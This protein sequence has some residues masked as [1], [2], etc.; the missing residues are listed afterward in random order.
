MKTAR[1]L[2]SKHATAFSRETVTHFF[3]LLKGEVIDPG[4]PTRNIFNFDEKGI[5]LG[6]GHKNIRTKYIFSATD[7]NRYVKKSDNLV[8]VTILECVSAVG[9]SCPPIFVLP[10]GSVREW[11]HAAGVG[12]VVASENGW[13]DDTICVDWFER[14]FVP[15]AKTES[16]PTYPIIFISDRHGSHET[17]TICLI[18]IQNHI[19]MI[20]PPPLTPCT[21]GNCSMSTSLCLSSTSGANTVMPSLSVEMR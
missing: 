4:I 10:K 7:V 19:K 1:G 3:T 21:S 13:M 16:D 5:Q 11:V 14:V 2:D 18:A 6:G 12:G 17:N 8:L 15:W 20:S 9:K